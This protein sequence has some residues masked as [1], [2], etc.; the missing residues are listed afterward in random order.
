LL[1]EGIPAEQV[2]TL[3]TTDLAGELT[4]PVA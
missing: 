4:A 2:R 1:G 3:M